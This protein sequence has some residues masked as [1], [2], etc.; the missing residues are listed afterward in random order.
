M[1]MQSTPSIPPSFFDV[2]AE[3]YDE[4]I[5]F[6]QAKI[7]NILVDNKEITARLDIV[8][9]ELENELKVSIDGITATKAQE[10]AHKIAQEENKKLEAELKKI[11]EDF[12][13]FSTAKRSVSEESASD[14]ENKFIKSVSKNQIEKSGSDIG[15]THQDKT[16]QNESISDL[17]TELKKV[18]LKVST[19]EETLDLYQRRLQ[20]VEGGKS[21]ALSLLDRVAEVEKSVRNE[22]DARLALL[23]KTQISTE[24][25]NR[26]IKAQTE[27]NKEKIQKFKL[28]L[29]NKLTEAEDEILAELAKVK[30]LAE[31]NNT[32]AEM[33]G[34]GN[35]FDKNPAATDGK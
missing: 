23:N 15:F 16:Q 8:E 12:K 14:G 25:S 5:E 24:K 34:E 10:I 9:E 19:N 18:Q 21:G 13:S 11:A 35:A 32:R 31:T 1:S 6:L 30:V 29:E 28:E 7:K 33:V 2:G 22:L 27:D 20:V 26:K 4:K 3:L 17:Q